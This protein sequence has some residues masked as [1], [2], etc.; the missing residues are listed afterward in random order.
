MSNF[1]EESTPRLSILIASLKQ[2]AEM[3]ERVRGSIQAQVDAL[4]DPGVVEILFLVDNQELSIGAKRNKLIQMAKGDYTCF[5]DDDDRVFGDYVVSLLEALEDNPDCVG[6]TSLVTFNNVKGYLSC[7]SLGKKLEHGVANS[8]VCH[9]CPIKRSITTSVP[10]LDA[11]FGEDA[12]W[13][14]RVIPLL[15]TINI[16]QQPIYHYR[17][18]NA[19]SET[20]RSRRL[21]RFRDDCLVPLGDLPDWAFFNLVKNEDGVERAKR[22]RYAEHLR[23]IGSP[24]AKD[25]VVLDLLAGDPPEE[26]I[27]QVEVHNAQFCRR[28]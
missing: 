4:P 25:Q 20:S 13:S 24:Y 15:K 3:F 19:V 21:A 7:F 2:R 26:P 8:P 28:I 10:F 14:M 11:S 9:L 23:D 12:N 16:I 22:K 17:W 27:M 1:T 6:I 18:H 5:V